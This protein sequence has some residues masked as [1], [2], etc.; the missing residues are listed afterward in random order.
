MGSFPLWCSCNPPNLP[1]NLP[2]TSIRNLTASY[3]FLAKLHSFTAERK[4]HRKAGGDGTSGLIHC[5]H[6]D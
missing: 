3:S 2:C 6:I 4:G 5:S 1:E